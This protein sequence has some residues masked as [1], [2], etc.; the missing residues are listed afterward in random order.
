MCRTQSAS[1]STSCNQ[2]GS[3]T[4]APRTAQLR[5]AE[6]HRCA[7][8]RLQRRPRRRPE[9]T[10]AASFTRGPDGSSRQRPEGNATE[11][12]TA[13]RLPRLA[14]HLLLLPLALRINETPREPNTDA[15]PA[16]LKLRVTTGHP[17]GP[18]RLR[19]APPYTGVSAHV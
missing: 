14:R 7:A 1:E 6:V 15:A 16:A 11:G 9:R 18:D 12:H 2:R 3:V 17:V 19:A 10:P 4:A 5:T 13:P 8:S